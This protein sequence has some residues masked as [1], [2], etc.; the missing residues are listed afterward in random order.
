[1]LT[2]PIIIAILI[3]AAIVA[4]WDNSSHPDYF[5]PAPDGSAD[6]REIRQT[7]HRNRAH[8]L[9]QGHDRETAAYAAL[10]RTKQA[11]AQLQSD[12]ADE[13]IAACI[14]YADPFP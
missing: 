9:N 8:L 2:P 1:M 11:H 12:Q 7:F 14:P 6:C 13:I 10:E 4:V 3:A 5:A